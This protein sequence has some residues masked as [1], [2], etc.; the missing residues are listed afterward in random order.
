MI[1]K[2]RMWY[3]DKVHVVEHLPCCKNYYIYFEENTSGKE[4]IVDL[5]RNK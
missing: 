4:I 3:H 1:I 2:K 5:M